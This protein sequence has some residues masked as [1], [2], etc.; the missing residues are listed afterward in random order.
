NSPRS[1]LEVF[2]ARIPARI[3]YKR[4]WRNSF[5]TQRIL[6]RSEA[7]PMRKRSV[8]EIRRL[9]ASPRENSPIPP[10]AHHLFQYLHLVAALGAR[11]D[12]L[13][14]HI[15]VTPHELDAILERFERRKPPGAG[16][17]FGLNAGAEYGPAKRWPRER[18]IETA[19][20]LHHQTKC[21]W[22]IFGGHD[23]QEFASGIAAAIQSDRS[24]APGAVQSL[25]GQIS[26]REL[27]AALK[28]CHLL[29]TNDTG[30]MHLGAAVGI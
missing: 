3:G 18:F 11:P 26:L 28:A 22:W 10:N 16:P 21:H 8:A 15:A 14:T 27:C 17:L 13:P 29:L 23:E 9:I 19:K 7:V 5:L 6:P 1:A 4:P 12:P 25:A 2:L 30:P 24:I 20:A